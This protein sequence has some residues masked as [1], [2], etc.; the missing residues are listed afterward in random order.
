MSRRRPAVLP[1]LLLVAACVGGCVKS[2]EQVE[3]EVRETFPGVP[4]ITTR[5]LAD[6]LADRRRKP[7]L[8]LDVRQ[9]EEYRVSH[10]RS[11]MWV[12]PE[13]GIPPQIAHLD[14]ATPIVA[15]CSVGFRSSFLVSQLQ[16]AG[17][18]NVYNLE[19]SI[20]AWANEGRPVFRDGREVSEV[21]P[22]SLS[23]GRLLRKDRRAS[24]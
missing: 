21:H 7:P 14:R 3:R 11:A 24:Y 2:L 13:G 4:Q 22:Y 10:L 12:D 6:W 17:F 1:L 16:A 5:E 19:G 9:P 23:W 18:T 15:Y 8:L 20:F